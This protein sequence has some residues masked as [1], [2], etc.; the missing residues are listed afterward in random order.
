MLHLLYARFWHK[1]LFDLGHLSSREPYYR[2]FNQGYILAEAFKDEREIYVDAFAID[3][4]DDGTFTYEGKPVTREYG[5]MGKSLKNA[6]TPDDICGSYGADT[7]RLYEMAMG[8]LDASRPWE[9]RDVVGMFR[10]LQR[11][12]RNMVDEES[13]SLRLLSE[14]ASI[15]TQR[16]LHRTIAG[17]RDDMDSLR[18]NTAIA[19][20][21]ELNNHLTKLGGCPADIAESVVLMVA[22][23]ASHIAEELWRRLGHAESITYAAF[24]EADPAMLVADTVELPVQIN[25]K[26]RSRIVVATDADAAAVEAIA[27]ADDKVIAALAGATPRKVIVIAG[28]TVNIVA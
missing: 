26:L 6:V 7:L 25:G 17:V 22:P 19:K 3:R 5:K 1:V 11:L 16:V 13:G 28:R 8:P 21:I 14:P 23:L 9:T 4:H 24:P 27:L 15:D 10:F 12:W 20:L 2:L 18:F